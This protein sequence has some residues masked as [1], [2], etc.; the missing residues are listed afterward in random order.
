MQLKIIQIAL[1]WQG[2]KYSLKVSDWMRSKLWYRETHARMREEAFRHVRAFFFF[3]VLVSGALAAPVFHVVVPLTGG[4][5]L[6]F[7]FFWSLACSSPVCRLT[8]WTLVP[9]R[10]AEKSDTHTHRNWLLPASHSQTLHL[11]HVCWLLLIRPPLHLYSKSGKNLTSKHTQVHARRMH[12]L[13]RHGNL[14]LAKERKKAL[15]CQ[16]EK[17]IY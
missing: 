15:Q 11:R 16:W 8:M 10:L 6:F 17:C 4:E 2:E 9:C 7:L 5:S 13:L 3:F 14:S 1:G 12:Q